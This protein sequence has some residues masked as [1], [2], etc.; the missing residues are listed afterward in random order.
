MFEDEELMKEYMEN[1]PEMGDLDYSLIVK[2]YDN[3]KNIRFRIAIAK[4]P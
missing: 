2:T 1:L 4:N 3:P